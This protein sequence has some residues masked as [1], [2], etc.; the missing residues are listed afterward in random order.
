MPLPRSVIQFRGD[1]HASR[2]GEVLHRSSLTNVLP[3]EPIRVFVRAPFPR[4]VGSGKV[5]GDARGSLDV[6]VAV[7]LSAVVDGD[8]LE[9]VLMG[10]NELNDPSIG[11]SDGSRTQLA[12]Q[13]TSGCSF[14]E[15]H[16]A[17]AV[18]G[19]DDGVHLPVSDLLARLDCRGPLRDVA[20][21]GEPAAL[22]GPGVP[23]PPLRGLPQEAKQ[24]TA[25][26]LVATNESVDRLVADLE[27]PFDPQTAADL[28]R[29]EPF[30]QQR[31]DQ[32]PARLV[33]TAVASRP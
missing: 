29:T 14:H 22:L 10:A 25:A 7:E 21:A 28:I 19:T 5:D 13:Y 24:L 6:P 2:L 31:D 16:D 20:L 1:G 11:G 12:D 3:D 17:V 9:Q 26:L 18:E 30:T 32:S 8:G 23:F 15:R 33:E 27:S 4:V